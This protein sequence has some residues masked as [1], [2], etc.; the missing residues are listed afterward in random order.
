MTKA[1]V[2]GGG[3]GI[4]LG[5]AQSLL[6]GGYDVVIAGRRRDTLEAAQ[7]TT[8]GLAIETVDAADEASAPPP[9]NP[10][11]FHAGDVQ[12]AILG[13]FDPQAEASS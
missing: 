8:P 6:Q 2:A 4:G 1:I 11:G 12:A 13:G 3:S 5:I 10:Y 9:A 7:R